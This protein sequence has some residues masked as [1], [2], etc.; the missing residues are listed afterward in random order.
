MGKHILK[1]LAPR[2]STLSIH[3]QM[4][5]VGFDI[6]S[7]HLYKITGQT[8]AVKYQVLA[9]RIVAFH[10]YFLKTTDKHVRMYLFKTV[11]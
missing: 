2:H 3:N 8:K 1:S 7:T 4:T 11:P 5:P 9:D 6:N 10:V